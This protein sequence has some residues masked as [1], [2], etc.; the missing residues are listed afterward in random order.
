MKGR[1]TTL[2]QG[3]AVSALNEIMQS[4]NEGRLTGKAL[5][6]VLKRFAIADQV[7]DEFLLDFG[8]VTKTG[9]IRR[10]SAIPFNVS[11]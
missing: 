1:L 4:A 11:I 6:N 7:L 10:P 3:P 8:E 2:S 5:R 9:H